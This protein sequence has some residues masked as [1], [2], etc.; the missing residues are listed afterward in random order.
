MLFKFNVL[1]CFLL[2]TIYILDSSFCACDKSPTIQLILVH[3][4][5]KIRKVLGLNNTCYGEQIHPRNRL[6][7]P[8]LNLATEIARLDYDCI[9]APS[10]KIVHRPL[11]GTTIWRRGCGTDVAVAN[12]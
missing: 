7:E 8:L 10:I 11:D 6:F 1:I 2:R 9:D 3:N 4:D 5:L 12:M